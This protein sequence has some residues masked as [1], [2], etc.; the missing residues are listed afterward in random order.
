MAEDAGANDAAVL[1]ELGCLWL[2]IALLCCSIATRP[3]AARCPARWFVNGVRPSGLY[4][5]R[6]VPDGNPL[7]DGAGG[8]PDRSVDRP[9]WYRSRVWCTGGAHPIVVLADGEARTVGCQR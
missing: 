9:G 7:Y 2:S 5:C 1:I 3:A 4:E 8:F 6:R